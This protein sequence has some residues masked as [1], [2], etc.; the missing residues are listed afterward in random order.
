MQITIN[1]EVAA[2]LAAIFAEQ[3]ARADDDGIG[4]VTFTKQGLDGAI[5]VAFPSDGRTFEIS[6]GG[7][8]E[9]A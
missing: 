5:V 1:S 9:E 4:P 8:V 7:L 2:A 3:A 6:G